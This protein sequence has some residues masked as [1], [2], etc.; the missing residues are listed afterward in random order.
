MTP[1]AVA[2][3]LQRLRARRP[4]VHALTNTVVQMRTADGLSALGAVPSMTVDPDEIAE[5][6]GAADALL[7][8]LGTL[9][10]QRREAIEVA[11][12]LF[13]GSGRPWVLDPV[14][15]DIAERRRVL[16]GELIRRS[17]AL[18]RANADEMRA[19]APT[20]ARLETGATDRISAGSRTVSVAN[21]HPWLA[22]VTGTGCLSGAIAAAFLA[23]EPDPLQAAVATAVVLGVAAE[24]GAARAEGPGTFAATL[25]DALADLSD[26]DIIASARISA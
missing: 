20:G 15:C 21:G 17:P 5:V 12:Q 10:R 4:R 22:L 13:G 1:A 6:A 18:V 19:L 26:K 25:L 24:K 8:N 11:V 16:A 14:K 7:V 9:D 23:V 2:N 3:L